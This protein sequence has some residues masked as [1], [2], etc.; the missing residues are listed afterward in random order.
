MDT[1]SWTCGSVT[2]GTF[3]VLLELELDWIVPP[4]GIRLCW[5]ELSAGFEA[6]FFLPLT[7]VDFGL[8]ALARGMFADE[9]TIY[10]R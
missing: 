3:C 5:I 8:L 1:G 7:L 4:A 10:L 2:F 6:G 9:S